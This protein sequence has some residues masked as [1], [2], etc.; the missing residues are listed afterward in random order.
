MADF[1]IAAEQRA[2]AKKGRR[3]TYPCRYCRREYDAARMKP[4]RDMLDAIKV[5]RGCADC[6]IRSTHPEI[7]D[8]DHVEGDKSFGLADVWRGTEEDA[9]AEVA[10]CEVVCANCHRIRTR[11]REH[12]A[13][14]RDRSA[15]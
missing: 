15:R 7:Y 11:A 8:F 12:P 14:G 9:L 6:G 5:E 2:S 1:Y 3:I 10:K 4:R 13:F